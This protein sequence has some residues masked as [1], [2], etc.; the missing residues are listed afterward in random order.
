M[1]FKVAD[2]LTRCLCSVKEPLLI[3][4]L[5]VPLLEKNK[6]K[7]CS[8]KCQLMDSFESKVKWFMLTSLSKNVYLKLPCMFFCAVHISGKK[9]TY[10]RFKIVNTHVQKVSW[11]KVTLGRNNGRI[12]YIS[13]QVKITLNQ[14]RRVLPPKIESMSWCSLSWHQA[15]AA[16]TNLIWMQK[17]KTEKEKKRKKGNRNVI[18]NLH[19]INTINWNKTAELQQSYSYSILTVMGWI[20]LYKDN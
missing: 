19:C 15:I 9:F 10:V 18:I 16:G 3:C 11:S 12:W 7:T 20:K 8:D 4:W 2:D 13:L 5:I 17:T 14:H 1:H 6:I